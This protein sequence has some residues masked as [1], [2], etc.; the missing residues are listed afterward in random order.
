MNARFAAVIA[1]MVGFA[2]CSVHPALGPAHN[3]F[4]SFERDNAESLSVK[5]HMGAGELRV[6]SGTE[7]LARADFLYNIEQWKPEVNYSNTGKRGTLTISQ[8]SSPGNPL[9]NV[10]YEW[11][12]RLNREVPVD[13]TAE[14]GA[15]SA[16]LDLGGLTMKSVNVSMG[17]GELKMDL[18]GQ[19][20]ND[21]SVHISGGVGEATVRLPQDVGIYASAVGGIGEIS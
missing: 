4:V 2:G 15:G 9:G 1:G 6:G 19:P 10:K 11:D 7:K 21:Y 12:L 17:V 16:T 8:P 14:L 5:L 3:E 13:L 18:R 20:K